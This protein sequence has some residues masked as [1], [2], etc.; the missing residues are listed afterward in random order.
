[1]RQRLAVMTGYFTSH[2]V[3]DPAMAT[4]R[5]VVALGGVVHRQ[6]LIMGFSDIFAVIGVL[7]GIAAIAVLFAR[8][9]TG[10]A[11]AH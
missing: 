9:T 1:M 7:L 8:K 5:A 10:A 3:T 11:A 6:A 4:H 2:G